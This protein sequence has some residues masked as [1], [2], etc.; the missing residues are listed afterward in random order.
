[1]ITEKLK[2][3][4]WLLTNQSKVFEAMCVACVA[5]AGDQGTVTADDLRSMFS[6]LKTDK[7]QFGSVLGFLRG[8]E[9]LTVTGYTPSRQASCNGR[10]IAL[11]ALTDGWRSNWIHN[12]Q[13]LG[14]SDALLDM[15]S[16]ITV[17]STSDA[18]TH[19]ESLID[20]IE[21][22]NT[23]MRPALYH[24]YTAAKSYYEGLK[25]AVATKRRS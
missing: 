18:L 20:V 23:E 4:I 1:M 12:T 17:S 5:I 9:I 22:R 24:R 16:P 13:T 21:S 10:P 15:K 8:R 6:D 19:F 14:V 2:D 7:R 11:F 25:R 3:Q